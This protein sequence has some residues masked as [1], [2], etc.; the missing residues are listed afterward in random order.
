MIGDFSNISEVMNH[1][2][3]F[4]VKQSFSKSVLNFELLT[5]KNQSPTIFFYSKGW[6]V[7][8]Q[9]KLYIPNSFK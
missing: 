2:C 1:N 9:D 7:G 4:V 3:T 8:F 5:H 6:E